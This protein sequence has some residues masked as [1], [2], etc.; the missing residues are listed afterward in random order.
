MNIFLY[1]IVNMVM[2]DALTY[3]PDVH[4]QHAGEEVVLADLTLKLGSAHHMICCPYF[5]FQGIV[6][7]VRLF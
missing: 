6:D 2:Q 7:L 1:C 5:C 4:C 3:G